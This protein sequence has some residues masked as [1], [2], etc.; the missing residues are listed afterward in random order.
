MAWPLAAPFDRTRI[1]SILRSTMAEQHSDL[2]ICRA[3]YAFQSVPI[4][5]SS[6]SVERPAP[7]AM[8]PEKRRPTYGTC[9]WTGLP[10]LVDDP[11]AMTR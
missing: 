10:G 3:S 11:D 4:A 7:E 2:A 6:A 1:A 8:P 5:T 9:T